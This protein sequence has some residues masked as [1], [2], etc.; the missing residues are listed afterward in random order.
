[1]SSSH[2]VTICV[3]V[4]NGR[5]FVADTLKAIQR[6]SHENFTALIS[7]DAS[8]D[9]S[10]DICRSFT[11]D[12]R[13]HLV[14]QAARLGWVGNC[15]WLLA[16]AE[17]ELVCLIPH[18]DLVEPDYIHRLVTCLGAQP[19]CALAFTDIQVFGLLDEVYR[20]DSIRGTAPERVRSFI[21]SHSDGTAFRG[22]IRRHA[23]KTAGAL[24]DNPMDNFAADVSWLARVAQAGELRRIPELLYRKRRHAASASL[25]WGD[26][27]D[28]TKAEAWCLHC[29]ELLRDALDLELTADEQ[30]IVLDAVLRRL[31]AI[32][33]ALPFALIREFPRPRQSSMVGALFAA[34]RRSAP[35]AKEMADQDPDAVLARLLDETPIS[36]NRQ[37]S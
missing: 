22:L 31:L 35:T 24:R 19:D 11:R 2:H 33:P 1:M 30:R 16:N 3:P 29:C 15:N 20:Q 14:V 5:S 32:E 17:S 28:E 6:Q 25:Q 13:F 26:W 10:P 12:S 34:L 9:G 21:A 18:D 7:D 37:V 27:T 4:Y 8:D 36:G 23:L